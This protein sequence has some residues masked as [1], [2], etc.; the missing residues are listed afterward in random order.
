M[1]TLD[2]LNASM[3]KIAHES[4][5]W[6]PPPASLYIDGSMGLAAERVLDHGDRHVNDHGAESFDKIRRMRGKAKVLGAKWKSNGPEH[7]A[8]KPE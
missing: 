8:H 1:R 6:Q 2:E 3:L 4:D 5:K 7:N